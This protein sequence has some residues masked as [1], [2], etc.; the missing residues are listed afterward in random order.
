MTN[1]AITSHPII[2]VP[3]VG[4]V[5]S[6][7]IPRGGMAGSKV[8]AYAVSF[9]SYVIFQAFHD[10]EIEKSH[11]GRSE[12]EKR[13]R[14]AEDRMDRNQPL[15]GLHHCTSSQ[16]PLW[17]RAYSGTFRSPSHLILDHTILQFITCLHLI[18]GCG[19]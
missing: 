16:K 1:T 12:R 13:G 6:G 18:T 14:S 7:E 11:Q 10:S 15:W 2:S 8:R 17:H 5:T 9:N 4:S 19:C 3:I